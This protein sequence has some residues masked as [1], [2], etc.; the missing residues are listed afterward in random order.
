[1]AGTLHGCPSGSRATLRSGRRTQ[2]WRRPLSRTRPSWQASRAG[3]R[4]P[5]PG[6]GSHGP[7]RCLARCRRQVWRW[8]RALPKTG[9]PMS[10][11]RSGSPL[12]P[13]PPLCD[14]R[15]RNQ[16]PLSSPQVQQPNGLH[17]RKR[18]PSSTFQNWV[19]STLNMLHQQSQGGVQRHCKDYSALIKIVFPP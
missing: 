8:A 10:A 7:S 16:L 3:S 11:E 1:M 6:P 15:I 17:M 4:S 14:V 13:P 5:G 9:S 18:Q 12:P 2:G 19:H